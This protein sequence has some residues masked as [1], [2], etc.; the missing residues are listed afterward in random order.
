MNTYKVIEKPSG[1][2]GITFE[3]FAILM[4]VVLLTLFPINLLKVWFELPK[5]LT[6]VSYIIIIA[7]YV[8]LR[9]I[10]KKKVP[11]YLYSWLAYKLLTPKHLYINQKIE[12]LSIDANTQKEKIRKR[13]R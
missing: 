3:D 9:R 4:V 6:V 12:A 8:T 10:N 13:S 5:W 2:F 7:T 11:G 1:I